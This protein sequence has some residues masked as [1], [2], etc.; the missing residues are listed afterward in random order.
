MKLVALEQIQDFDLTA[1]EAAGTMGDHNLDGA[2]VRAALNGDKAAVDIRT[3]GASLQIHAPSGAKLTMGRRP[4]LAA[5]LE[6]TM[7]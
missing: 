1:N 3:A 6:Y 4:A 2:K 7:K 5:T